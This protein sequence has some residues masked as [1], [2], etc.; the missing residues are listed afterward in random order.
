MNDIPVPT[1]YLYFLKNK[2]RVNTVERLGIAFNYIL[3]SFTQ[4]IW[5][6]P[7]K[8]HACPSKSEMVNEEMKADY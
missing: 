6:A 1:H 8:L 5:K 2:Y 7:G 3:N 4:K